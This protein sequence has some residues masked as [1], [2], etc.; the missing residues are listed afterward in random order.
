MPNTTA[1]MITAPSTAL[2]RSENSGARTSRVAST[3]PAGH[4]RGDLRPRARRLVQRA[5]R[6]A[7]RH[8]HPLEHARAH[9]RHP[10]SHGLLVHVDAVAMPRRERPRIARGLGEPDQQQRHGRDGDG[11]VVVADQPEVGQLRGREARAARRRPAPPRARRDRTADEA[12]S[13]PATSTSAPGTAG[14]RRRSPRITPSAVTPTSRVVQCVS[15]SE[16][17]HDPSSRHALSPSADV[18]VSLGS[19]PMTTST[20]A[21]ARNPVTTAFDRKLAIHPIRRSASSRNSSPVASAIAATSCAA[22]SPAQAGHHH[23][24]SRDGRKRRARPGRD[25]P[26]R[27][28]ERVDDPPGGGRVQAVLQ[29]HPGDVRVPEVLRHHQGGDRDPRRQIAAQPAP[30]VAAQR[31]ATGQDAGR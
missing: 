23:R 4:E 29:R 28:E 20:A 18:P 27:A 19:S 13:P 3:R 30:V 25:V 14:A 12:S 26:G 22:C 15:P 5:G 17:S 2:G 21:P 8:R 11:R 9:V 16:P 10:L 31:H 7:G 1:S 24:A 6:E